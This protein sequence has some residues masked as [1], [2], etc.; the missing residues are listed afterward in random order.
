MLCSI[1]KSKCF[2]EFDSSDCN[3]IWHQC[4]SI[5]A[6]VVYDN[7]SYCFCLVAANGTYLYN[8]KYVN[9]FLSYLRLHICFIKNRFVFNH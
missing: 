2:M 3:G 6:C 1:D 4:Y 9:D 7:C 5:N 8:V